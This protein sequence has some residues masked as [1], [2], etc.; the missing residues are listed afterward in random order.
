MTTFLWYV[1]GGAFF[2]FHLLNY[3]LVVSI[4]G[5][6]TD[7]YKELGEPSAFHFLVNRPSYFSHPYSVFIFKRQYQTKLKP[8]HGLH[9]LAQWIFVSLAL[10]VIAALAL[11][12]HYA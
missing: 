7:L 2:A 1:F 5:A 8:F 12:V 11:A 3:M 4:Y 10:A 6:H 9:A